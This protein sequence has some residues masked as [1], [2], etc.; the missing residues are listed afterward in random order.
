M[1]RSAD[2]NRLEA[3][4]QAI[5]TYPGQPVGFFARLLDWPHEVISRV[6]VSL[7]DSGV[8]LF[9]DEQGGIWPFNNMG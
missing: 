2:E 6:L 9:E 3:L 1:P 5:E 7:N 8:L 4:R